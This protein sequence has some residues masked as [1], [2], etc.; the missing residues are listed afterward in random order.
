MSYRAKESKKIQADSPFVTVVIKSKR[1]VI[2]QAAMLST[3]VD[4]GG[5]DL[6]KNLVLRYFH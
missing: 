4:A 3:R 5:S 2:L 1:T 6:E